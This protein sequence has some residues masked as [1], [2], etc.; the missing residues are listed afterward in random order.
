MKKA[1]SK[2]GSKMDVPVKRL[3]GREVKSPWERK[4]DE[5]IKLQLKKFQSLKWKYLN[6]TK[7][8]HKLSLQ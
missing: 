3:S 1:H 6:F 4:L 7:N 5:N 8:Q 2:T